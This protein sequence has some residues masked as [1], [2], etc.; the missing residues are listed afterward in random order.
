MFRQH[1]G[2]S[3]ARPCSDPS[4]IEPYTSAAASNGYVCAWMLTAP[5]RARA[6]NSSSSVTDPQ[7]VLCSEASYGKLKKLN[8]NVPPPTPTTVSRPSDA[9]TEDASAS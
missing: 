6:S 2:T 5:V 1:Q 8:G 7:Y 4:S 9:T 3:T